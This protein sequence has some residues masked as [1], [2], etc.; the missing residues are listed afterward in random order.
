MTKLASSR[1]ALT[2]TRI[3]H[4]FKNNNKNPQQEARLKNGSG[5]IL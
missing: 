1:D 4:C 5:R 2:G 3:G